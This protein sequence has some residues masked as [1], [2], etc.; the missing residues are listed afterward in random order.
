MEQ[1]EAQNLGDRTD[2][3][4]P[5][6]DEAAH[7]DRK[8]TSDQATSGRPPT[9]RRH[10]TV[11]DVFAPFQAERRDT[12]TMLLIDV[13]GAAE[14]RYESFLTFDD[15]KERVLE[16]DPTPIDDERLG[17]RLTKLSDEWGLL[18][19]SQNP[20]AEFATAE[21][22]ERKSLQYML[23]ERG[24]AAIAGFLAAVEALEAAGSLQIALLDAIVDRLQQLARIVGDP[25]T[26]D[27]QV[28][29]TFEELRQHLRSLQENT[30]TFWSSFQR[31]IN[32]DITEIAVFND[33]K[34]RTLEYI[35]R[36]VT[37]LDSC[38]TDAATYL[39]SV[40]DIG[41]ATLI[42]RVVDGADLH[43]LPGAAD[44]TIKLRDQT[45]DAYQGVLDWFTTS[46][47]RPRID[48]LDA[49]ARQAVGSLLD[50]LGRLRDARRRHGNLAADLTV[51]AGWFSNCDTDDD[52]HELFN[53]AFGLWPARH[54]HLDFDNPGLH[55]PGT[56][57]GDVPP[58]PVSPLLRTHGTTVKRARTPKVA[59]PTAA[60]RRNATKAIEQRRAVEQ[61]WAKLATD[62]QVHISDLERLDEHATLT[63]LL[64]LV[65]AALSTRP[66]GRG[67]SARPDDPRRWQSRSSDGRLEITLVEPERRD[68][69]ASIETPEG[70]FTAPDF[71]LEIVD[72]RAPTQPVEASS[73]G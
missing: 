36:F 56:P 70:T 53:A 10:L 66:T 33:L 5:A 42:A 8:A 9:S 48:D 68:M 1:D 57:W 59:D 6:S 64:T 25:A 55:D 16:L 61:A 31:V 41:S 65:H 38:R 28:Y 14:D 43:Q 63:H 37:D 7:A 27:R 32:D 44:P 29:T 18:D 39:T 58:V 45:A 4:G 51:L 30:R 3:D 73:D 23:S 13:F 35:E 11:G 22:Y 12:Y 15:I 2:T 34:Q 62:G 20:T 50:V 26:S 71:Q 60:R 47:G 54:A 24:R 72:L 52:A 19:A 17:R 40:E 67:R 21:E 49:I 69:I 46:D